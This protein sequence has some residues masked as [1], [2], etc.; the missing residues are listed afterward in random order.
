[1]ARPEVRQKY[2]VYRGICHFCRRLY[3]SCTAP[4]FK[5][6]ATSTMIANQR[7]LLRIQVSVVMGVLSTLALLA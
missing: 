1:M 2:S 3:L 7:V 4:A 5:T 6:L